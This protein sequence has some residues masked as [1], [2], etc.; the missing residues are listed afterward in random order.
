MGS[1][2][3]YETIEDIWNYQLADLGIQLDQ[4]E[5]KGFA[6]LSDKPILWDRE[7]GIAFKT[8]SGKIEF[9]SSLME[10]HGFPSLPPYEPLETPAD[11]FRLIVG[12]CVAHTNVMTQNNPYLNELVPENALWIHERRRPRWGVQ[13]RDPVEVASTV[14]RGRL[15]ALSR[16]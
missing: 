15:K 1:Y 9:V 13:D 4:F 5:K 2:F 16:T 10:T 11:Q 14:G 7:N 8:P 6:S 12:R 3:P